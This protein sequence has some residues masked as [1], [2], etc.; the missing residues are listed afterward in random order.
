[1]L[2]GASRT[3]PSS[4]NA[5]KFTRPGHT[6]RATLTG[7]TLPDTTPYDADRAAFSR[8]ALARLV[9]SSSA[10][11]AASCAMGLVA[12]RN[13]VDTGLG[14]RASQ[15]AGL[16]EAAERVLIR[17]VVYERERGASWEQIAHYLEIDPDLEI[18]PA[19]A[20]RRFAPRIADWT[21][22]FEVPYRLDETGRKHVPQLPTAAYDPQFAV[23]QLDLWAGLY[24]VRGDQR[25]VSGGLPGYTPADDE[26]TH[27]GVHGPD[28][29]TGW[30]R[31]DNVRP[32]LETLCRYVTRGD[33]ADDIDWDEVARALEA[34]DDEI[35]ED[36]AAR[37]TQSLQ[38]P[39]HTLHVCLARA[40]GGDAVSV[41]VTGADSADLRLRV[42]TLLDVFAAPLRA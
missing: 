36:P 22:A 30:I 23:R 39:F 9:L 11:G 13:D 17:A 14:G 25:A 20:E 21:E 41:V 18:D 4:G 1:M 5:P 34:T 27:T 24:V 8:E 42:D 29:M 6:P 10:Q 12:T 26:D 2:S 31:A 16:V 32:F 33:Y 35:D 3:P 15:A 19:E 28:E 7:V 38:G 37:Y 40:I